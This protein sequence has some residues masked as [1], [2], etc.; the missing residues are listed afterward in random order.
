[1]KFKTYSM[2]LFSQKLIQLQ[3]INRLTSNVKISLRK[4]TAHCS[5]FGFT[6]PTT[7]G[8]AFATKTTGALPRFAF[9]LL[10][11]TTT[12]FWIGLPVAIF[13]GSSASF[14]ATWFQSFQS[15]F[16]LPQLHF[17]KLTYL[18]KC[19]TLQQQWQEPV[20]NRDPQQE[21]LICIQPPHYPQIKLQ[22]AKSHFIPVQTGVDMPYPQ[23]IPVVIQIKHGRQH[24]T[25]H[26][27]R[28]HPIHVVQVRDRVNAPLLI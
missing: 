21:L 6:I 16:P 2:P 9:F 28:K 26:A 25:G 1:M 17:V 12:P 15:Q 24:Q 3:S 20:Q 11:S 7:F 10:A 23:I 27:K 8:F 13:Y 14:F 4:K 22:S 19:Q 5:G 18:K